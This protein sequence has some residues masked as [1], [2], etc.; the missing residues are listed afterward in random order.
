MPVRLSRRRIAAYYAEAIAGGDSPQKLIRELAAFLV[1]TKRINEL[2]LIVRDIEYYLGQ[3]GI[4]I[5]EVTTARTLTN[6]ARTAVDR[7]IQSHTG[8]KDIHLREFIDKTAI[9]G[10]RIN[11]PGA[12]LDTTLSRQ[13][14]L[15][16]TNYKK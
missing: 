8:S 9:G 15:L 2:D 14:A 1:E 10:T 12:R 5:A 3:N 4:V 13:L 11:L 6:I 16:R 7:M